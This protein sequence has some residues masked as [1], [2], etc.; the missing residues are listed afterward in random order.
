MEIY[1]FCVLRPCKFTYA[2]S[3][4]CF[5]GRLASTAA[6][7]ETFRTVTTS[8]G[9]GSLSQSWG[10]GAEPLPTTCRASCA[11]RKLSHFCLPGRLP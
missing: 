3:P 9:A 10:G 6:V 7:A 11:S 8:E 5:L 1:C 2:G 4:S